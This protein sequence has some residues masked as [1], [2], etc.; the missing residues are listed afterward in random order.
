MKAKFYPEICCKEC[1]E[2]IHNHFDCPVCKEEMAGTDMY[3]SMDHF[4]EFSCQEC[5]SKFK[6]GPARVFGDV[7]E[8]T[9]IEK[10]V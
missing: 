3:L 2:V 6:L 4:K 7:R 10:K 8:I 5:H 9:L 1:N